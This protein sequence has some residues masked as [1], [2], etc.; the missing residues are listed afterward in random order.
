MPPHGP[1]GV[2][3]IVRLRAGTALPLGKHPLGGVG[4]CG[5]QSRDTWTYGAR[6]VPGPQGKVATVTGCLPAQGVTLKLCLQS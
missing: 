2:P 3:V 4:A 6:A 1:W 5:G